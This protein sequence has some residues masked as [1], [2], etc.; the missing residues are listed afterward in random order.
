MNSTKLIYQQIKK[1]EPPDQLILKILK[2]KKKKRL[3][4]V[5]VSIGKMKIE[6][7]NEFEPI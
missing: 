4:L 5:K 2:K 7:E 3:K 6:G 1:K